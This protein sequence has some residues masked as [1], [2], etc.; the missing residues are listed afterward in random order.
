MQYP[1]KLQ[2]SLDKEMYEWVRNNAHENKCSMA[3]VIRF[4]LDEFTKRNPGTPT[5]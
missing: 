1:K 3:Q 5:N 4:V 2:V